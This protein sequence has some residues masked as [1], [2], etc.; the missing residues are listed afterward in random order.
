MHA[1]TVEDVVCRLISVLGTSRARSILLWFYASLVGTNNRAFIQIKLCLPVQWNAAR[2]AN[3]LSFFLLCSYGRYHE[4]AL[5]VGASSCLLIS[6]LGTPNVPKR[7]LQ[8]IAK[9]SSFGNMQFARFTKH[10][11]LYNT[12]G[13]CKC[14]LCTLNPSI[15]TTNDLA[16]EWTGL[17]HLGG[18]FPKAV[19]SMGVMRVLS[20]TS[21]QKTCCSWYHSKQQYYPTRTVRRFQHREVR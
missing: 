19:E 6:S 21:K 7:G 4:Q 2:L 20:V 18:I 15:V 5:P 1:C 13:D 11:L 16:H 14:V 10:G 12:N 8:S 9:V 17:R 3:L